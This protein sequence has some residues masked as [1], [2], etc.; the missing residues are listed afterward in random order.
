M[1]V[2]RLSFKASQSDRL[3][4]SVPKGLAED[5][6]AWKSPNVGCQVSDPG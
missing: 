1:R 2:L 6:L 3:I 4:C 5:N